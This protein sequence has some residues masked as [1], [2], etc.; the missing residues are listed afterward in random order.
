VELGI[1]PIGSLGM[2]LAAFDLWWVGAPSVPSADAALLG[3][4][5]FNAPAGSWRVVFDLTALA[6]FSGL[7]VVPLYALIQ[8]RSDAAHRSRVIAGSNIMGAVF[9]VASSVMLIGLLGA[10]MSIPRIFGILALLNTAVAVYIYQI[11]PEFLFRFAAWVAANIMYRL[12]S[13]GTA[14]IPSEGAAVLVANHVSFVDWLLVASVCERPPR[15]VMY[16]GYEKLPF[17]GWLFRDAKVIPIAPA[18]ESERT[19]WEAFDRIAAELEAGELVCVFPEGKLT[20]DGGLVA[21]RPGIEK[22]VRRT[23]VPVVPMAIVGMWGSFFSRKDGA[24]L[25]RPFR[26]V[27]S[28]VTLIAGPAVAPEQ[29]TAHGLEVA[30]ADLGGFALPTGTEQELRRGDLSPDQPS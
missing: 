1:V 3:T 21:F 29:V 11:I 24:P 13:V 18:H 26:R 9:M 22:I 15:F 2:S 10:G 28:R 19:M 5:A 20:A 23:P 12:R 27:W 8:Q 4:R 14:N 7:F 30:V 6:A 16:H 25:R 17:V